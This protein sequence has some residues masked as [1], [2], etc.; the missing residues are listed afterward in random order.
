MCFGLR[1]VGRRNYPNV[2]AGASGRRSCTVLADNQEDE[3]LD[4]NGYFHLNVE[5]V[6][7]P[8]TWETM[9]SAFN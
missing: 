4:S 9:S 5:T 6:G 1:G 8:D 7:L 3:S 2:S